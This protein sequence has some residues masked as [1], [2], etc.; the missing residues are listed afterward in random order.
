M[1]ASSLDNIVILTAA[2][3]TPTCTFLSTLPVFV[4]F[5][6]GI[7]SARVDVECTY[8]LLG[9]SELFIYNS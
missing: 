4:P 2:N 1:N 6:E 3:P 5:E 8:G 9:G 7:G